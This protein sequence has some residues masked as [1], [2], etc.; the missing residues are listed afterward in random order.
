M[1]SSEIFL[2]HLLSN[3][4]SCC[5]LCHSIGLKGVQLGLI[6]NFSKTETTTPAVSGRALYCILM[7]PPTALAK[8][9][10]WPEISQYPH[11][12]NESQVYSPQII[13]LG[14]QH[15]CHIY[16]WKDHQIFH[17]LKRRWSLENFTL[18]VVMGANRFIPSH[19]RYWNNHHH[20]QRRNNQDPV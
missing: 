12:E 15:T 13:T 11:Q 19:S 4:V 3:W 16:Q 8:I 17:T 10:I 5:C 18:C 2:Q 6:G 9:K 1:F 7:K 20:L 14:D